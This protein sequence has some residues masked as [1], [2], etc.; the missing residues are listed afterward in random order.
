MS[1]HFISMS[2]GAWN[3]LRERVEPTGA[4]MSQAIEQIAGFPLTREGTKPLVIPHRFRWVGVYIE[5]DTVRACREQA[6]RLLL[7][8]SH[9]SQESVGLVV[10]AY[11]RKLVQGPELDLQPR[12]VHVKAQSIRDVHLSINAWKGLK[13][14]FGKYPSRNINKLALYKASF[15]ATNVEI[16]PMRRQVRHTKLST[17]TLTYFAEWAQRLGIDPPARM[18]LISWATIFLEYL[19]RGGVAVVH[20]DAERDLVKRPRRRT[21]PRVLAGA[22]ARR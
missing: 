5:E 14:L 18:G 13:E 11:L 4:S 20:G 12:P 3:L 19:G 7:I 17:G 16:V 15:I 8:S 9:Q 22:G 6:Q 21:S 10:E 1:R 2:G